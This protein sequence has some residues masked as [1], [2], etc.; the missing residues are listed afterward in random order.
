MPDTMTIAGALRLAEQ[1]IERREAQYL[2]ADLL[3]IGR[4]T[5]LAHTERV[6]SPEEAE[7]FTHR[8][9]A[10]AAGKPVAYI[11]GTRE[12]YGREFTV[13]EHALI[14][15]PE[16]EILVDQALERLSGHKLL[17]P[18]T[19]ARVL[20]LGTGSGA[21]AVTLARESSM[22]KVAACDYSDA[23]LEVARNNAT[24]LG[25][26]VEFIQSNWFA[27]LQNRCFDLIV[28][29]PPYVAG[30]DKHL[31]EGDLRFEP[32][33]ALTDGSNDGLDSIRTIVAGAP[34]HLSSG[35]WLLFEHGFDQADT[36]RDLLLKAGFENLICINDLAG[37]PRVSGG[38]IR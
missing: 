33:M 34:S 9:A 25:A 10:R 3:K 26:E 14:P 22:A 12:F 16:T 8:V 23:A 37:I 28:S 6:M 15:R 5:L 19:N 27:A 29:N 32:E 21:I 17:E 20:D 7:Q 31:A 30:G 18:R 13:N 38:Q 2:L 4:A 35:G 11:L 24:H 36:A 1:S